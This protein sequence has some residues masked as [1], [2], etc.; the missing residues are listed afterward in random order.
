MSVAQGPA[1]DFPLAATRGFADLAQ[2]GRPGWWRYLVGL[3]SIIF[4]GLVAIL[5]LGAIVA[6]VAPE[7]LTVLDV[8]VSDWRKVDLGAAAVVFLIFLGSIIVFLPITLAVVPIVHGR[9]W[10][11]V[12]TERKSFGWR[13]FAVSLAATL[14]IGLAGIGLEFLVATQDIEIVFHGRAFLVF[15]PLVLL[16]IPLQVSAEEV[17]FRGYLYQMVGRMTGNHAVRLLVP[18]TLFAGVHLANPEVE[19]G[20]VWAILVYVAIAL[21]LGWLTLR[22]GGLEMAIGL[23]LG[24]NLIAISLVG[25]TGSPRLAPTVFFVNNPNFAVEFFATVVAF[26]LHWLIVRRFLRT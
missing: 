15:L 26:T 23:H 6:A 16:L 3:A 13:F 2:F 5:V 1:A 20:G 17:F 4:G 25:S 19:A 24:N 18:A 10:L 9:R 22:S 8:G 14:G 12:I 21:Y 11:S 7:A